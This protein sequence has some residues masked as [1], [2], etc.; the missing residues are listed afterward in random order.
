MKYL[1]LSFL[2]LAGFNIFIFGSMARAAPQDSLHQYFLDVGQ[3]DSTL[4]VLPGQG[5][6]TIKILIDAGNPRSILHSLY[7]VLPPTDRY[8]D[9]LLL[10]HAQQDHFGGFI[11]VIKNFKVGIFIW[12]GREGT[13][14]SWQTLREL[15]RDK[16]IRE[17]ILKEGDRLTY[18]ESVIEFLAPNAQ[19]LASKEIN[20]SA[21]VAKLYSENSKTL[22]T[23]DIGYKGLNPE[24]Y[25]INNHDIDADILKVG[26]HGSRFSTSEQFLSAVSP[27]ISVIGVGESNRYGHPTKEV[28][29][30]LGNI[31]SSIYRTDKDKTVHLRIKDGLIEVLKSPD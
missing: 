7:D 22:F 23:A 12:N 30:R 28:I 11:D 17:V 18:K 21:L 16:D 20:D 8:I 6:K 13:A 5:D 25:L 14:S 2:A 15:M 3:G 1:L 31:S 10:T 27:F 19:L 4:L 9:V 26:H 29:G 24:K